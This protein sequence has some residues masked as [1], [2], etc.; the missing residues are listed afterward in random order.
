MQHTRT[1]KFLTLLISSTFLC[2]PVFGVMGETPSEVRQSEE[3]TPLQTAL[4]SAEPT[5]ENTFE[6]PCQTRESQ[7]PVAIQETLEKAYMQN[8]DLDA[9]R[10]GL[11]ATDENV[12]QAIADWRPS[13]TV[14][15]NQTWSQTNPIGRGNGR[16]THG[17]STGYNADN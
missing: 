9:A 16:N 7:T 12:S 10:A 5:F 17:N 11:R 2:T 14:T 13:A 8:T 3:P 15:G 4:E 1:L 6:T